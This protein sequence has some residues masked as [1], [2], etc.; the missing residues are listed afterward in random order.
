MFYLE[1]CVAVFAFF[2]FYV[3]GFFDG[4]FA[5]AFE[6]DFEWVEVED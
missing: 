3:F 5:A 4:V 2:C 6:L 1:V